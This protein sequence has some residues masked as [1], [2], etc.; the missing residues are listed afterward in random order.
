M[1]FTLLLSI[2]GCTSPEP[3]IQIFDLPAV[4][5]K[6]P[7]EVEKVLGKPDR[8]EE[9]VNKGSKY[10]KWFWKP[11]SPNFEGNSG[12]KEHSIVFVNGKADWIR[13]AGTGK[14][15]FDTETV[16]QSINVSASAKP[17]VE[18]PGATRWEN[19]NLKGYK[20][21]AIF[22]GSDGK[23]SGI[24]VDVYSEP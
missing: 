20:S 15:N 17:T 14:L 16:L 3:V 7:E 5:G 18:A 6:A 22:K 21:V 23:V 8:I 11:L 19:G 24:Y 1:F 10:P 4:A 2:V 9:T 12:F 13:I